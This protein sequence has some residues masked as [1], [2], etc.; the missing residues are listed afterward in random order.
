[1]LLRVSF[2]AGSAGISVLEALFYGRAPSCSTMLSSSFYRKASDWPGVGSTPLPMTERR[3]RM[4]G[5]AAGICA[6]R[7]ETECFSP[8]P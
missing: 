8:F 2:Y 6:S 1:M 4:E 5:S 7:D 3:G